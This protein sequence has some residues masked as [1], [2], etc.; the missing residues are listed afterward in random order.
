MKIR[1]NKG[2]CSGRRHRHRRRRQYRSLGRTQYSNGYQNFELIRR[3]M[4]ILFV[5]SSLSPNE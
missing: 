5:N 3:K 1:D 2:G 4:H